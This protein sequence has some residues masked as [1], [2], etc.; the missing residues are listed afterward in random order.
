MQ[1][2]RL[3]SSMLHRTAAGISEATVETATVRMQLIGSDP[4]NR[5]EG[6]DAL[7]GKAN[8]LIGNDPR[9]WH[10]DVPTYAKVRFAQIYRGIDRVYYGN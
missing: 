4:S 6:M 7:P 2:H 8:Y 10:V 3:P 9:K 5:V 1:S